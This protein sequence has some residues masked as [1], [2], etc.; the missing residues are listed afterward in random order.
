MIIAITTAI[1]ANN[2]YTY[3][4]IFVLAGA[5]S[6]GFKLSFSNLIFIVSPDEKR[7]VYIAIQ[8]NITSLGMFFSIPGGILLGFVGYNF[9]FISVILFLLVG[10]FFSFKLKDTIS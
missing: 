4:V 10:L 2:L 9:L 6:D 3:S 7:P 8:N 1:F 5:A